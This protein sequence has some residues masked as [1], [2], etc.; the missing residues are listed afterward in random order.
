M[1]YEID[2]REKNVPGT[3]E[4][5]YTSDTNTQWLDTSSG[6]IVDVAMVEVTT[7]EVAMVAT[8][9]ELHQ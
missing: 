5:R 8:G 3:V 4:Y 7:V 6:A 1:K 9:E 2:L